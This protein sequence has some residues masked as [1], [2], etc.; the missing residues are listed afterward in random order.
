[1]A[2]TGRSIMGISGEGLLKYHIHMNSNALTAQ[3]RV[4][5][6][7]SKSFSRFVCVT[8]CTY[9]IYNFAVIHRSCFLSSLIS[10]SLISVAIDQ[11]LTTRY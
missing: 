4:I 3:Y 11:L 10:V 2:L 7:I 1:M 5:S 8:V 9:S 6:I